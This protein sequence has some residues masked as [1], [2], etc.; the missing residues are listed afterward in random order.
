MLLKPELCMWVFHQQQLL[1]N[2]SPLGMLKKLCV[3]DN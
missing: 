1:L 2:I 3:E